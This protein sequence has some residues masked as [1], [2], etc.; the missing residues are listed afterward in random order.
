M[1]QQDKDADIWEIIIECQT[2]CFTKQW[3]ALFETNFTSIKS[4]WNVLQGFVT[5]NNNLFGLHKLLA[6]NLNYVVNQP[7]APILLKLTVVFNTIIFT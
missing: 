1:R 7:V 3:I 5:E 4:R 6:N 2:K